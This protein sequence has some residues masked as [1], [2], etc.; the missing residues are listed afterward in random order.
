MMVMGNRTVI[1]EVAAS[2]LDNLTEIHRVLVSAEHEWSGRSIDDLRDSLSALSHR[3]V[4]LFPPP[5]PPSLLEDTAE[6]ST[7][8]S[9]LVCTDVTL[10]RQRTLPHLL[11]VQ[12][13]VL[14]YPSPLT[15][16]AVSALV[17]AQPAW[18][19]RASRMLSGQSRAFCVVV[20]S[21][22]HGKMMGAPSTLRIVVH[23]CTLPPGLTRTHA[24]C[25]TRPSAR[26]GVSLAFLRT[27]RLSAS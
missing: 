8:K 18:A 2:A 1:R 24:G 26:R 19:R 15:A 27:P 3:F 6:R 11:H 25:T 22:S 10:F 12:L 13:N 9:F 21:N 23:P 4:P 20:Q 7:I 14:R 17:R 16:R 5:P